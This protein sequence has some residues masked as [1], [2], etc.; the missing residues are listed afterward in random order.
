MKRDNYKTKQ[1]DVIINEIKK[2]NNEFTIKDIYNELDGVG[3]TTIY[4]LIDKL[5]ETGTVNKTIGKD[6][7]TYYQYLEECSNDNHFFLKCE[8]CGLMEDVD[9][10]CIEDLSSHILKEHKFHLT[11]KVI[12]NGLCKKCGKEGVK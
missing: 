9:C 1:K 12:I 11:D 5:V 7:I 10:D 3:L 8:S 6:N 2:H 4:R